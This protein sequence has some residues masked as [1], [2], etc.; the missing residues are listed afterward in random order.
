MPKEKTIVLISIIFI[1]A[2]P[3]D[4][5]PDVYPDFPPPNLLSGAGAKIKPTPHAYGVHLTLKNC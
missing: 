1:L 2:K 3:V 4:V 5:V